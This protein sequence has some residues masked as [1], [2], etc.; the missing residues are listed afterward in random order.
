MPRGPKG[1][2]RPADSIGMAMH[3]RR[4]SS[5]SDRPRVPRPP[6]K[7]CLSWRTRSRPITLGGCR[8]PSSISNSERPVGAMRNTARPSKPPSSTTGLR[9]TRPEVIYRSRRPG[10]TCS[11]SQCPLCMRIPDSSRT[12]REVRKVPIAVIPAS[13]PNDARTAL[14]FPSKPLVALTQRVSPSLT[15]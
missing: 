5:K 15:R 10:R 1:E 9:C 2:R 14:N 13:R 11:R 4:N 6:R 7:S 8:L 3:P 12:S